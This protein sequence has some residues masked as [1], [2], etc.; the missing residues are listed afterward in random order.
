MTSI[1]AWAYSRFHIFSSNA[2]AGGRRYGA[3][4]SKLRA[5]QCRSGY[6][7]NPTYNTK[8]RQLVVAIETKIRQRGLDPVG[9]MLSDRKADKEITVRTKPG[10]VLGHAVDSVIGA[11]I[12]A[13]APPKSSEYSPARVINLTSFQ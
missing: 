5:A 4:E 12:Y 13:Y 9:A 3:N 11:T 6:F 1:I 7:S 10:A 8:H 2:N